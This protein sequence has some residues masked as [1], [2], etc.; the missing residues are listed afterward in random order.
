M[1]SMSGNRWGAQGPPP[2]AYSRV[3]NPQRFAILHD[4]AAALLDRLA[5]EFDV[6]RRT[7]CGLDAELE[8]GSALARPS[9]V[10]VPRDHGA[11]TIGVTFSA[12]PG[13]R[14]RFGQS[15]TAVF[16]ACGCDACDETADSEIER[17]KSLFDD[18]TAGRFREAI[19]VP[20]AGAAWNE[21]ELWSHDWWS[22]QQS[23]LDRDHA[24]RL[25]TEIGGSPREWKAWPSR[26]R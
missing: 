7:G 13:L 12:F 8:G 2:E 26:P 10:L 3:T 25:L 6:E 5:S 24:R 18:V 22:R 19:W 17:L 14:V 11:A 9:V 1:N 16:P 20:E 15:C 21:W 23:H 4:V